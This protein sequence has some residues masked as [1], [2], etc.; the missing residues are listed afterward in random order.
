MTTWLLA[1][2]T[3]VGTSARAATNFPLVQMLVPGFTVE[4]LPVRLNNV[5]NLRFAP[6]GSLTALGYD[7]RIW[8]LTD[9]DGD[10]LEDSAKPF[11][12]RSTLSI[13]VGMAW[14]T[15]GLYVSSKGKLSLLRDNDGDGEAD[16]EE[17]V[18]SGWPATDVASGGVD[19]SSVTLDREGNAYFALLVADYSNAYRLRKHR[20]LRPQDKA[21]LVQ[22]GKAAEGNPDEEVSLYDIRS[23]RGTIQKWDART[24]KLETIAT[25][26]RVP[27]TLAFN[28]AG[29]L[30]NTDQEGETWMPY[31][32]P[33][34]ELNHIVAGRNYGFPPRHPKWLPDVVSEAP[35][36]GF[37]PQHQ[38][39]CG[40]VFNEPH[41]ALNP[42]PSSDA[43]AVALPSGPA[44]GLFGPKWW[45]GDAFVAGESRGQIWRVKMVKTPTGYVGHKFTIARLQMLTLDFA[46]SPKGDLYV[47]CHS[48]KPDWGTGPKGDGKIFRIRYT[49]P[50]AAQPT[51]AWANS[52]TEVRI[53]FDRPVDESL[54]M[55]AKAE[56]RIEFGDYVSAGDQFETLKPPYAV[57]KQQDAIPRGRLT[58]RAAKLSEDRREVVLTTDAHPVRT[59]YVVTI[60]GP[61]PLSIGYNLTAGS[62]PQFL[63]AAPASVEAFHT[64]AAWA[65]TNRPSSGT[66]SRPMAIAGADWERGSALFHGLKT[67]CATCHR[68]RG[69]GAVVGPDL[70]NLV[71]RDAE[72]ILRDIRSPDAT[73]HPDYITY[74]AELKDDTSLVGFVREQTD[75]AVRIV[76]AQG[77]ETPVQRSTIRNL[78]PTGRSLMPA[79]LI[80][81]LTPGEV[82]DLL[83]YL[84]HEPPVRT[85]ADVE[86]ILKAAAGSTP[87]TDRPK[88]VLVASKQD[89]G[90]LQH[91]YPRWQT[92]WHRLLTPHAT[93]TNA[94]LWPTDEQF[95]SAK[96][97]VF[98]YWNRAWD[99]AKYAQLDAYL[100]RGGG[101]VVL[102]SG[103]IEDN[104]PEKLAARI[105]LAAHPKRSKYIH[106]PFD[107]FLAPA[108]DQP[109]TAGL[110]RKIAL[111]DEPYWPMIGDRSKVD[112]LATVR[113]DGADQPVVWTHR[114]GPGRVWATCLGHYSWTLD[115]PFFRVLVLRGIAWAAGMG[116][117]DSLILP[118]TLVAYE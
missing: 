44:Q 100:A 34:D 76:D 38:S 23:Q 46:I 7:G 16:T 111:I 98:Y 59:E 47:C 67:Q 4:E 56:G 96:V 89:H 66:S 74:E 42:A 45:D 80:D 82:N 48:G 93:V 73:L 62:N 108:E 49:D 28:R 105:G 52:S 57:V 90:A 88:I 114:P 103:T 27:Y 29:D 112:V 33:L 39:T 43:T 109:L 30:F 53:G 58:I 110:P 36:V 71:H 6:D 60:P 35:V 102:H 95:T 63:V 13:P 92:N 15:R 75:T 31:G 20:D 107:L 8:R 65:P 26:M 14:S 72:S 104:D 22:Q 2:F 97:V 84:M 116:K 50:S 94:W 11:W 3:V 113:M 9:S 118:D 5:N 68:V 86:G 117:P 10:G 61:I 12:S 78:H 25:G 37:G 32:N 1:C 85:R 77:K 55:R 99:D 81:A 69:K 54:A 18:A 21:W 64:I 51:G 101:V 83:T 19:A 87:G 17:V 115:D 41:G 24:K 79:G 91:D 40:L 70:S 106:A